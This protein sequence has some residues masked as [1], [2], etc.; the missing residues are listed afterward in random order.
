MIL[1]P[2]YEFGGKKTIPSGQPLLWISERT[3][4]TLKIDL[5]YVLLKRTGQGGLVTSF[6]I[7]SKRSEAHCKAWHK[8]LERQAVLFL[9]FLT[10]AMTVIH[11]FKTAL[12]KCHWNVVFF[13]MRLKNNKN[14]KSWKFFRANHHYGSQII[15]IFQKTNWNF[16]RR[17][18]HNVMYE[19]I[20]CII[21]QRGFEKSHFLM[22][23]VTL[24]NSLSSS[25]PFKCHKSVS[26]CWLP[27]F[28]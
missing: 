14:P 26:E 18:L 13:S 22:F 10:V 23:S 6:R 9:S 25:C 19:Q 7:F 12:Q 24:W 21:P 4:H 1:F 17:H 16:L 11:I 2:Y 15:F 27:P 5:P 20:F 8:I 3:N 28:C